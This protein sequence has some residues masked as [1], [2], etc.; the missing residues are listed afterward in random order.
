MVTGFFVSREGDVIPFHQFPVGY[1]CFVEYTMEIYGV[2]YS[3]DF[4]INPFPYESQQELEP[5]PL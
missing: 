3:I 2:H 5:Y 4:H 1:F